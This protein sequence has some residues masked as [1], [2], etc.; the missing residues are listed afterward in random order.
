MVTEPSPL[1]TASQAQHNPEVANPWILTQK[2][3]K[4]PVQS[5]SEIN[6]RSRRWQRK[7]NTVH[8]KQKQTKP[9]YPILQY[10]FVYQ[11]KKKKNPIQ[12]KP[13]PRPRANQTHGETPTVTSLTG[14]TRFVARRPCLLV[15][16]SSLVRPSQ[17][18]LWQWYLGKE[19]GV[20]V[21]WVLGSVESLGCSIV[22][23]PLA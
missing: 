9:H 11:P 16:D 12:R 8:T 23:H 3:K 20:V 13:N 5:K 10:R 2:K 18:R 1:P 19:K 6:P 22:L 15:V 17:C 7:P 21:W 4:N 14:A